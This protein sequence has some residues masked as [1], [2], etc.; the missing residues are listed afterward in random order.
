MEG[1]GG[2]RHRIRPGDSHGTVRSLEDWWQEVT[3]GRVLKDVKE[4]K[5]Y[6]KPEAP[7]TC[8]PQGQSGL[9]QAGQQGG[10]PQMTWA[11]SGGLGDPLTG[12]RRGQD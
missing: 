2:S 4:K 8:A 7:D 11:S 3:H 1:E 12:E 10:R 5:R 9:E 6:S